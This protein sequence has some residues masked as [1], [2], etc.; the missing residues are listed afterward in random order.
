MKE[1]DTQPNPIEPDTVTEGL[2][3]TPPPAPVNPLMVRF[4]QMPPET[5]RLPSGGSLYTNGE[6]DPEVMGGEV[7][8]YPMTTVDEITMRSPDMLFQGTAIENVFKRCIPQ[9]M[10]PLD[11]LSK[12]VD[13]L[14]ICLRMITYGTHLDIYWTCPKCGNDKELIPDIEPT[15]GEHIVEQRREGEVGSKE[16]LNAKPVYEIDLNKFLKGTIPF[17]PDSPNLTFELST[18]EVVKLK[19]STFAEMITL[20]QYDLDAIVTPDEMGDFIVTSLLAVIQ[21]VN[22]VTNREFIREW[23]LACKAP[24]INEMQS[25]IQVANDWGTSETYEF[26]CKKCNYASEAEIPLNPVHFF[27]APSTNPTKA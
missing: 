5:F 17:N 26:N 27:T 25:K 10:K 24:V 4:N 13:Y 12:D 6:L 11:L 15:D 23:A 21:D 14:L 7:I 19:P 3:D 2:S 9:V 20:Y 8:I 18:G 1:H 16:L 22:G